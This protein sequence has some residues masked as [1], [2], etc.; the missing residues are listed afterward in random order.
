MSGY[1]RANKT[2]EAEAST[3]YSSPVVWKRAWCLNILHMVLSTVRIYPFR[4]KPKHSATDSHTS[5]FSV[6]IISWCT[7]AGGP[8]ILFPRSLNQLLM[9]LVYLE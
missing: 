6:K 1:L 4:P 7:F 3:N 2:V 5:W 9:P 8:K